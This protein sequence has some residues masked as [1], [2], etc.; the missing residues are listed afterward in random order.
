M[1]TSPL[2]SLPLPS[3]D[4]SGL[5][6]YAQHLLDRIT[7]EGLGAD[8]HHW[9]ETPTRTASNEACSWCPDEMHC[10]SV[11]AHSDRE[12]AE[13]CLYCVPA[14]MTHL[15]DLGV[16]PESVTLDVALSPFTAYGWA[17]VTA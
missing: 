3:K 16:H 4:R 11:L 9:V 1:T 13:C 10:C 17:G 7:R 8:V 2:V 15:G 5:T 6:A 12:T 14:V